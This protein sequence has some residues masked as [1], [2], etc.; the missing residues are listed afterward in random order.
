MAKENRRYFAIQQADRQA[1]IYIFGD[2]T[3]W[4]FWDGEVS[5]QSIIDQIKGLDVDT[6]N[7]HI[8]SY[9]GAVS[10]GWAIYSA[11]VQHPAKVKTYGDGFVASAALFPFLA[12]DERYASTLSAYYLHQV[13]STASGYAEDLRKAAEEL[14]MFT[15][16]GIQAFVE[17]AGMDADTVRQLMEQETWLTPAQAL[18]HG[19]VTAVVSGGSAGLTQNAKAQIMQR[20]LQNAPIPSPVP[21]APKDEGVN[22]MKFFE[23]R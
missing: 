2:I 1:D 15:D 23:R 5:A 9:G 11:L 17:R 4:A 16:V 21:P 13:M 6:I 3:P 18:E 8:D 12:G 14:D 10:E 22:I 20:V 19:I 7:V